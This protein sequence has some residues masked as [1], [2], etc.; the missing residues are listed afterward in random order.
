MPQVMSCG[1]STEDIADLVTY[2][3]D[4]TAGP[5]YAV[6]IPTEDEEAE[7]TA[8]L[9]PKAACMLATGQTQYDPYNNIIT[10]GTHGRRV[11]GPYYSGFPTV[12]L[13][14]LLDKIADIKSF[15]HLMSAINIGRPTLVYVN[16]CCYM[17]WHCTPFP[18]PTRLTLVQPH[19]YDYNNNYYYYYNINPTSPAL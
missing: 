18:A 5:G 11:V 17:E 2:L 14:L 15:A 10:H 6:N 4:T 8:L 16:G 3:H 9:G 1:I 7:D 19:T 13:V 12:E